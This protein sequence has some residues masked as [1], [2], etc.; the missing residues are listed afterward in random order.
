MY[1]FNTACV[2][3]M[4]VSFGSSGMAETCFDTSKLI[5]FLIT[6]LLLPFGTKEIL[7]HFSVAASCRQPLFVYLPPH[8]LTKSYSR[9]SKVVFACKFYAL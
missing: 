2:H 9:F 7:L 4:H 3:T 5:R 6:P 8:L 1:N